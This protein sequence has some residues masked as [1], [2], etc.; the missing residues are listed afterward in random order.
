MGHRTWAPGP[1]FPDPRGP[2]VSSRAPREGPAPLP[3]LAPRSPA[4]LRAPHLLTARA[5]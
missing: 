2:M 3:P 5:P 1:C 4:Q